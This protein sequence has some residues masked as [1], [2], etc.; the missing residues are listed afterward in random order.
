VILDELNVK[1]VEVAQLADK[2]VNYELKPNFKAIGAKFRDLVPLIKKALSG[3]I[4]NAGPDGL[5]AFRAQLAMRV[6]NKLRLENG[7]EVSLSSEEVEVALKAKEGYAAASGRGVVVVLDTHLTTELLEEGIAREL[8]N[9]INGWRGDL[10]LAYEQRIRVALKGSVKLEDV[11]IKF[12]EYVAR[13]TLSTEL[14]VGALPADY[15]TLEIEIDGEKAVL[16]LA[17]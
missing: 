1:A 7:Q 4:P 12:S 6:D 16:G 9:R 3:A 8:V 17:M 13:E 2:Y 5:N 10:K 11:A 15:Q 14:K